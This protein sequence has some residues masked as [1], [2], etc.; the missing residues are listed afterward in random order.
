MRRNAEYVFWVIIFLFCNCTNYSVI[1]MGDVFGKLTASSKEGRSTAVQRGEAWLRTSYNAVCV[2]DT[3]FLRAALPRASSR[4]GS[5]SSTDFTTKPNRLRQHKHAQLHERTM[6]KMAK[7]FA[8]VSLCMRI[9]ESVPPFVRYNVGAL[10]LI[11]E[12]RRKNKAKWL[13]FF[14]RKICVYLNYVALADPW[15]KIPFKII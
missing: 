5:P 11:R 1:S 7:S 8:A 15:S 3:S 12:L 6:S 14:F 2:G 9:Y 13:I 10:Y 4:V